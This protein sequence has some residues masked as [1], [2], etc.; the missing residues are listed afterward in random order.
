M[1]GSYVGIP[2]DQGLVESGDLG[3]PG[4]KDRGEEG[5]VEREPGQD[6]R[7]SCVWVHG[8]ELVRLL[9][10][11][12]RRRQSREV[13][14]IL[15]M[16]NLPVTNV[17]NFGKRVTDAWKVAVPQHGD[18]LI[19][20]GHLCWRLDDGIR[21]TVRRIANTKAVNA[22]CR[23][24]KGVNSDVNVAVLEVVVWQVPVPDPDCQVIR[25]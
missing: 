9:R 6:D 13:E 19:Q 11:E 12:A 25:A 20:G 1:S 2:E 15:R 10:S 21:I 5:A 23:E 14:R 4:C 18:D 24:A 7:I 17:D 8:G 16:E 22:Q 3:V